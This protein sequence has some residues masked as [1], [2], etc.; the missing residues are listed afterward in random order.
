MVR[1]QNSLQMNIMGLGHCPCECESASSSLWSLM[2]DD[3]A[4]LSVGLRQALVQVLRVGRVS[5]EPLAP[6]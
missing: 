2:A 3:S 6:T 5:V 4:F 1:Q